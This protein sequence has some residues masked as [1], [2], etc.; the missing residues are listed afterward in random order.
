LLVQDST[1]QIL[2]ITGVELQATA[3]GLNIILQGD[4]PSLSAPLTRTEGNTLIVELEDAV[5]ALPG[6]NEFQANNPAA[7]IATVN[8]LQLDDDTIGV[9]IVGIETLPNATINVK[10]VNETETSTP[11]TQVGEPAADLPEAGTAEE[12]SEDAS[13]EEE[14]I[15]TGEQDTGYRLPNA[16]TATKTDTPLRDIPQSI[17]VIPQQVLKDQQVRNLTEAVQNVS[18]VRPDDS[19][20]GLIDRVNIRGF[21]TDVFLQDGIRQSQFSTR[22]TAN[23]ERIEVLKG[24]A[25]VLYGNIEPGGVINLVTKK[26]LSEP[27]YE[28]DLSVGSN[29]FLRPS[30]DFSGPLNPDK[31]LLYRFNTVYEHDNGFRDFRTD[32]NRIFL[33]PSLSWK[34]NE[35]TDLTLGFSYLNDKIPFDEGTVA[36]G[37]RV[38]DIPRDRILA[39]ANNRRSLEEYS[40][41]YEF[42]HRFDENWK[43]RNSFRFLSSDTTNF[44]LGHWF[45]QDNGTFER[46]FFSNQD[47]YQSYSLNTDVTG[48]FKTGPVEHTV[49][50][51]VDLNRETTDGAQRL[52]PGNPGFFTNIFTQQSDPIP[53]VQISD[54]TAFGRNGSRQENRLGIYLQDQIKVFENLKFLVGGRF[55]LYDRTS[56]DRL[57]NTTAKDSKSRFSPRLG[58]VYQPIE[59]ISLYASYSQSFNPDLFSTTADGSPLDPS[60]GTQYEVGIKG[61][62]LDKKLS[63]TLAAFRIDKTNIST[64]DPNDPT[65]SLAVGEVRSQGIELDIVGKPL[66]GWNIIAAYAYTDAKITQDNFFTV[67]NRLANVPKNSASLWSTYEIQKGPVKGLG[68]GLGLLYVGDRSGDLDNSFE[69]PGYFRTD[70]A[71]FYQTEQVRVGI[72]FQN[73]FDVN[74]F[75]SSAQFRESVYVGDPFTVVGS[76]SI[77]F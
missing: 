45:I 57:D 37:N 46:V 30:L 40:I 62:F 70:A 22:E 64:S 44:R 20:G 66:P 7:G 67:G 65:A 16:T 6:D 73:L 63:T 56:L 72:N 12:A 5:L 50:V 13:D 60:I 21:S 3:E 29:T 35:K 28:F 75:P 27:Y 42:E 41:G 49:L 39:D 25:S 58:I 74:Y 19:F 47:T 33:A 48:T 43:L 36:I 53:D 52:L 14:L 1:S 9:W 34:I 31:T 18:G 55:D 23:L 32:K 15:V 54:L 4:R 51:G 10:E 2:K 68:F 71:I 76:V 61:E 59:P 24:P 38:A 77:Q 17:Q 26:P 11:P 69:L 8:V